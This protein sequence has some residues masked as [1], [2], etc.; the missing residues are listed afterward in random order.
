LRPA[1]NTILA[2]RATETAE[3]A[4]EQGA[5]L[6]GGGAGVMS[7]LSSEEQPNL[8]SDITRKVLSAPQRRLEQIVQLDEKQA[9]AILKQ[10]IRQE[11]AV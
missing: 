10:W 6:L 3:L 11:E 9:A 4:A 5:G 8:V 1:I 2:S 7:Q